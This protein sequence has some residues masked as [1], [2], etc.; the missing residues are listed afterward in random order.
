LLLEKTK[1]T[2]GATMNN[3]RYTTIAIFLHWLMAILLIALFVVGIY[4]SDL[5]LSPAKLQIYAW[6][7]WAGVTVFLLVLI[8]LAWRFTH[9]PPALPSKTSTIMRY[10]AYAG[11]SL[12]YLLMI[13]APISGWLMSSTKGFQTVYFGILPIPDL[14]SKN[15]SLGDILQNVHQNLNFL[16][17]GIVIVH[18]GAALKH[19]WLDKDNV[20]SRI[21]FR[22]S[23]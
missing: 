16:F 7:K 5:P 15:K 8:R 3:D 4:M 20:L 13:A 11:H 14:L 9:R 23:S 19:R 6:H 10:A 17:I 2:F 18:V 21:L 12:L 22:H 1:A